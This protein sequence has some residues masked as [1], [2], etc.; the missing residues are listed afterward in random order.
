V[1]PEGAFKM[2]PINELRRNDTYTGLN[3]SDL[4]NFSKFLH[5]RPVQNKNKKDIINMGEAVFNFN[6]LDSIEEDPI[7]GIFNFNFILECWSVQTE[8]TK[9]IVNIRSLI[10]PG[11]FAY[12]KANSQVFGGCYIG[13]G[14]KNLDIAFMQ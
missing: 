5:F 3:S 8:P 13:F 14:I 11:Y 7:K 6:F 2:L 10:W 12:H 1:V 9:T 4:T